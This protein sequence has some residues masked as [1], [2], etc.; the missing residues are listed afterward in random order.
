MLVEDTHL[1][2]RAIGI[3]HTAFEDDFRRNVRCS[4]LECI[5]VFGKLTDRWSKK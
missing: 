3:S 4:Q 2:I 5:L 1:V